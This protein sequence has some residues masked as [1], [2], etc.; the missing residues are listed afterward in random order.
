MM[1]TTDSMAGAGAPPG[2]YTLGDLDVEVG[3][4]Q[5]ARLASTGRLAGSTLTMDRAITN[6][7]RFARI[8]LGSA[9]RM[10]A[11]NGQKLFPEVKGEIT[12]GA[13]AELAL[14]EYRKS[15]AVQSTWVGGEKIS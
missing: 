9:I 8:D 15:L 4:D 14:F 12:S 2:R 6:V 3:S 11:K 10:A 1:L 13:S 7:I 5:S